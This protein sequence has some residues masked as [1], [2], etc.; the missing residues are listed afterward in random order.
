MN[1][2]LAFDERCMRSN[3]LYNQVVYQSNNLSPLY[4][5]DRKAY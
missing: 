2:L 3:Q 5:G 1:S 4:K